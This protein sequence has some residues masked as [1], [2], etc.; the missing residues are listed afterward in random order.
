MCVCVYVCMYVSS[1]IVEE[2]ISQVSY[3]TPLICFM[4]FPLQNSKQKS[5]RNVQPRNGISDRKREQRQMLVRLDPDSIPTR[6][7]TLLRT[8]QA[9]PE[10]VTLNHGHGATIDGPRKSVEA[11]R[12]PRHVY[13]Y[14]LAC[15]PASVGRCKP[16][17]T[18]QGFP[19][20]RRLRPEPAGRRRRARPVGQPPCRRGRRA[21]DAVRP[22]RPSASRAPS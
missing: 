19:P 12:I 2:Y 7:I 20:D 6:H 13:E 4:R 5:S 1:N 22:G 14:A 18:S 15:I 21:D 11:L 9:N 3:C 17:P 10:K 16:P 8:R